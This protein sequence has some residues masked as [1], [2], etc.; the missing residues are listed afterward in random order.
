MP[1]SIYTVAEVD[2]RIAAVPTP[3]PDT[4]RVLLW[5]GTAW[6]DRPADTRPVIF[7]GGTTAPSDADLK[8]GDLWVS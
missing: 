8:D 4:P 7:V 1:D 5:S 3:T 2:S 6:P